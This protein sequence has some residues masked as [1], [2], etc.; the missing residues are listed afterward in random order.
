[1][2]FSNVVALLIAT[3]L[4]SLGQAL[5]LDSAANV[6][7]SF[8]LGNV[9]ARS[10][11]GSNANVIKPFDTFTGPSFLS[12]GT[13]LD[14]TSAGT[15]FDFYM[16][17]EI[18]AYDGRQH[19][20]SA[21]TM[22]YFDSSNVY[23]VVIDGNSKDPGTGIAGSFTTNPGDQFTL[24]LHSPEG[25][26]FSAIDANN[27]GG[28]AFLLGKTVTSPGQVILPSRFE[29]DT[30]LTFDLLAGDIILF[31]EDS[32]NP[33]DTDY[34]DMVLVVRQTATVPEPTSMLLLASGLSGLAAA[35]RRKATA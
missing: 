24:A 33:T 10:F 28:N 7:P 19:V 25:A 3:F 21:N 8:N 27:A 29:L 31:F 16:L 2:K 9:D 4:P 1:M 15:K 34:N 13:A 6:R 5:P 12:F 20:G 11:D 30:M 35:R 14:T 22:G 18:A 32:F 23:H 26:F 17:S